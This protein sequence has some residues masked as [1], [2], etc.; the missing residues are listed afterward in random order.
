[1][2]PEAKA[3]VMLSLWE[4]VYT[5]AGRKYLHEEER[6][7]LVRRVAV[8]CDLPDLT[9]D[10][11]RKRISRIQEKED[12]RREPG[13]GR[14]RKF[15]EAH[16]NA[17]R[18]VARAFGGELSRSGIYEVV[19]ERFGAANVNRRSQFLKWL[20]EIF[21]RRR[22]RCK[23]SLNENQKVARVAYARQAVE[24]NFSD[25]ARTIFVDEKRFEANSAGVYNLPVEDLTPTKKCNPNRI[26]CL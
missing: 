20:S 23:P 4:D 2:P 8:R 22:I 13:S 15:T 24:S 17:A 18:E 11:L 21:K 6:M 10:S 12:V 7:E 1:M 5:A 19:A 3:A 26:R 14:P 25:E 16:A 9:F